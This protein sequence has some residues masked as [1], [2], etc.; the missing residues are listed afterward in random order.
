MSEVSYFDRLDDY[1]LELV[2]KKLIDVNDYA[3]L[4]H[5]LL[6]NQRMKKICQK[7][8]EMFHD[9]KIGVLISDRENNFTYQQ[10]GLNQ[11]I[12]LDHLHS[13][14]DNI[15]S[16]DLDLQFNI[17][18]LVV[19]K[20]VQPQGDFYIILFSDDIEFD[21]KRYDW[22]DPKTYQILRNLCKQKYLGHLTQVQTIL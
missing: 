17:N 2:C 21:E 8:V 13:F 4:S 22:A 19:N 16:P 15:R 11:Y 1:T 3:T 14:I 7:F 5:L 12:T 10:A 18:I 6:T 9:E 20:P